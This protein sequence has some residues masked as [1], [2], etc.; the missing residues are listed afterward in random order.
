[1]KGSTGQAKIE[2]LKAVPNKEKKKILKNFWW[3]LPLNNKAR[4]HGMPKTIAGNLIATASPKRIGKS[5]RYIFCSY[6]HSI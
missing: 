3:P 4:K 5:S 2:K 6:I 1:M